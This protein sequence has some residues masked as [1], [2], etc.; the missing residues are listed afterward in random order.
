MLTERHRRQLP[1]VDQDVPLVE[2]PLSPRHGPIHLA[3][4]R[5]SKHLVTVSL[6]M[7][8]GCGEPPGSVARHAAAIVSGKP[9]SGSPATVLLRSKTCEGGDVG[10]CSGTLISP[11]VVLTAAHCVLGEAAEISVFFGDDEAGPGK[12]IPA[13]RLLPHPDLKLDPNAVENTRGDIGL[14]AL[15][16]PGPAQPVPPFSGDLAGHVGAPVHIVGFGRTAVDRE[17]AGRKREGTTRLHRL[18][19]DWMVT[20]YEGATNCLADSGGSNYVTVAGVEHVAGVTS[21][22]SDD[23]DPPVCGRPEDRAI[24][25][26]TYIAWIR[27]F[28]A[29]HETGVC[30]PDGRC[31]PD[32]PGAPAADPD[33]PPPPPPDAGPGVCGQA[34]VGV[35]RP[36]AAA[37]AR[38]SDGGCTMASGRAPTCGWMG[39]L[40]L[41]LGLLVRRRRTPP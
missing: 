2:N 5:K 16:E 11:R 8:L 38:P 22:N 37:G 41:A 36:D 23:S 20:G 32:C 1:L 10:F 19:G 33:C 18:D 7:L 27:D 9:T 12:A 24:R 25:T 6:L 28:V 39:L 21:H 17:D 29:Q 40:A 34:G 31:H 4:M 3:P 35:T 30:A 26:D 13:G 15:R 14:V